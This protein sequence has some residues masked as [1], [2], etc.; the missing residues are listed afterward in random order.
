MHVEARWHSSRN[1]AETRKCIFTAK[2][3]T[4]LPARV[5]SSL[6]LGSL[7]IPKGRPAASQD[8]SLEP[9]T[10]TS[11]QNAAAFGEQTLRVCPHTIITNTTMHA[12]PQCISPAAGFTTA[13]GF[14][15]ASASPKGF[16]LPQSQE[17]A[18]GKRIREILQSQ[19]RRRPPT[20]ATCVSHGS[21][22]PWRGGAREDHP[23]RGPD[24][25]RC[26]P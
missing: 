19:Q 21:P 7:T 20:S 25:A 8:T 22:S 16:A 4:K 23:G 26:S 3:S 1:S 14:S 12:H 18:G 13:A 10:N 15:V 6:L 24:R 2:Y 11:P 17:L 5:G 9:N